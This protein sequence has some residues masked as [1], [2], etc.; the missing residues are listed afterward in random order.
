MTAQLI[1]AIAVVALGCGT[2]C[3]ARELGAIVA[4]PSDQRAQRGQAAAA[5]DMGVIQ[6]RCRWRGA[7]RAG[8]EARDPRDDGLASFAGEVSA[9]GSDAVAG[10]ACRR[11]SGTSSS[12][13]SRNWRRRLERG[14]CPHGCC[15]SAGRHSRLPSFTSCAFELAGLQQSSS[16]ARRACRCSTPARANRQRRRRRPRPPYCRRNRSS[17]W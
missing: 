2:P 8:R 14:R 10:R 16:S 4:L 1:S 5:D 17:R 3:R 13:R 12:S 7:G 6:V 9:G 11:R 15:C